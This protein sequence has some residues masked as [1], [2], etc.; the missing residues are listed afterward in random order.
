[1]ENFINYIGIVKLEVVN[2][3]TG[4]IRNIEINNQLTTGGQYTI[5]NALS[6]DKRFEIN[7]VIFG[8]GVV[9]ISYS[10]TIGDITNGYTIS[11][12]NYNLP[13]SPTTSGMTLSLKWKLDTLKYNGFTITE[14]GLTSA[15]LNSSEN[16]LFCRLTL[17][18]ANQVFKT[19][20]ISIN[21][22]W[23][24]TVTESVGV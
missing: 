22:Q 23:H 15:N 10:N 13:S 21:G 11:I 24:I 1:M 17:S 18:E 4:E 8:N 6:H 9:P 19:S 3:D 20:N 5:L 14:I 12:L 16:Y 7:G 2:E